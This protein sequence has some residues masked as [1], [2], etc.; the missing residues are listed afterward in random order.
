MFEDKTVAENLMNSLV[1]ELIEA[2]RKS[3]AVGKSDYQNVTLEKLERLK[4]LVPV[5]AI[6]TERLNEER[7]DRK[8]NM[9]GGQPFTSAMHS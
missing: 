3:T 2:S 6:E 1:N 4:Q 9:F 8:A 5:W 7:I